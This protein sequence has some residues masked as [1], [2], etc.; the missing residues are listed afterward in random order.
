M[1][2]LKATVAVSAAATTYKFQFQYG[3]IKSILSEQKE[4]AEKQFQFQYG[5]IKRSSWLKRIAC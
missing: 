1:V 3:A 2:R 4:E 5:A